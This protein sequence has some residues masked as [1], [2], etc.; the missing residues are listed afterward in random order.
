[1]KRGVAAGGGACSGDHFFAIYRKTIFSNLLK[2]YSMAKIPFGILGPVIGSLGPVTGK[3]WKGKATLS[4]H[5][6]PAKT[7]KNPTPAQ[8]NQRKKFG[9]VS[10]FLNGPGPL[11]SFDPYSAS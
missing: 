1:M 4:S 9:F 2:F 6:N 5:R 11:V 10:Q 7:D 3:T 8:L